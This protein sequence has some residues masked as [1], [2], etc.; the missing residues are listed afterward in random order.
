MSA[1]VDGVLN[2]GLSVRR[3]WS[4]DPH[5]RERNF[6]ITQISWYTFVEHREFQ[7]TSRIWTNLDIIQTAQEEELPLMETPC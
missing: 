6:F 1:H 3:P 7:D 2:G 5:R 4:E